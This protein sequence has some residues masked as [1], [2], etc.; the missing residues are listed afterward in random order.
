MALCYLKDNTV[1]SIMIFSI[2]ETAMDRYFLCH[3]TYIDIAFINVDVRYLW[4]V[5][6]LGNYWLL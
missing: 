3:Y 1:N 4:F 6:A 2:N 5:K